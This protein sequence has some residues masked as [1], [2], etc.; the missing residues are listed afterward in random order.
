[1][2]L[3]EYY[4]VAEFL[5]NLFKTKSIILKGYSTGFFEGRM[6]IFQFDDELFD[7]KKIHYTY[8]IWVEN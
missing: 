6:L 3:A 7:V 4:S 1:M 8:G 2:L 5:T